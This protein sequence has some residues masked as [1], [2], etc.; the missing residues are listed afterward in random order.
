[1]NTTIDFSRNTSIS[2]I[3]GYDFYSGTLED[4]GLQTTL[5]LHVDMDGL[6]Y[7]E[8]FVPTTFLDNTPYIQP[9]IVNTD[10]HTVSSSRSSFVASIFYVS[11]VVMVNLFYMFVYLL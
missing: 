9:S 7:T 8:D 5:D 6:T 11:V 2:S 4:T 1:M 3:G 10:A